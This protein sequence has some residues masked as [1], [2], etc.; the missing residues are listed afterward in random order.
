MFSTPFRCCGCDELIPDGV[1]YRV[2]P[3]MWHFRR[4]CCGHCVTLN[5]R[6]CYDD[7]EFISIRKCPICEKEDEYT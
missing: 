4:W 2:G 6:T 3:K 7:K 1:E 5:C